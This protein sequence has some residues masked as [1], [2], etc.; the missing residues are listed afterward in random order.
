MGYE[1][2]I[3]SFA[4]ADGDGVGDL[5][6][7]T[8]H[9]DHLSRLGVDA[10]WITPF[11]RTPGFDH[12]YD[13]SDYK[14]VDPIH[15]TLGDFDELV[16]RAH[17]LGL[18]VV[19]D[20]V[21]NHTSSRHPW[22][23]AA[24][25]GRD[26]PYR[27]YYIWKDPAP[28]GGPPNN[29]VS[30]FGGSAW[31]FDEASGQYYC[32]LFLPEQP[33]L[34]W[35][36]ERVRTEI[37]D[38]LRFWCE[39]GVDGFRIDVAQSFA[40]H[41]SFADNPQL[42][43]LEP[44]MSNRDVWESFE[45]RYDIDQDRNPRTFDRWSRV[46]APHGAL[47]VGEVGLSDPRRVARYT[48]DGKGLHAALFLVPPR[49]AWEPERLLAEVRRMHEA[50]PDNVAWVTDNHDSSRSAS[51][52]GGGVRGARRSLA[53]T[54]LLLG[55]GG[56]PF[57]YQGQELGIEDGAVR[58]DDLADPIALRNE[59]ATGRD[60]TRTAMPWAPG[61]GNG[62][63]T[64]EPWL[65]SPTRPANE[66]VSVQWGEPSSWL[67]R[68]RRL[69]EVRRLHPDLWEARAEWRDVGPGVALVVRGD[70]C[71]VANFSTDPAEVRLP[72][73]DW[74]VAFSSADATA[75]DG[76]KVPAESAALLARRPMEAL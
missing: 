66:T 46:V 33:D 34:N 18:R 9:L 40:K 74:E 3:R 50:D 63:T 7:I 47:L 75:M 38:V 45:H 11:Y 32:H 21:A 14:D 6:G 55:L 36:N 12:G 2:Y 76:I 61:P 72:A 59:G 70:V 71:V 19:V 73:G 44:G 49:M 24:S 54:T 1:I 29:W 67:N 31:T 20:I 35:E 43:P 62:F 16:A 64:G 69:L 48:R 27:D 15:G 41:P 22:F 5:Q 53:L 4:D 57:L 58:P 39:R 10:L 51:R 68:H 25:R 8:S 42:R 23:V 52:F 26:D 37:D 13:V 28:D 56:V 30:Y 60:G 17:G 65:P